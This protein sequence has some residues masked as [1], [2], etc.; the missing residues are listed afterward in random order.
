MK[1][2]RYAFFPGCVSKGACRELYDS[3]RIITSILGIDLVELEKASCCG[4]GVI[5]EIKP[6][7]ADALNTRTLGMASKLGLPIMT[8]C[9][10]C[11][12]VLSQV[13]HR[14]KNDKTLLEEMNQVIEHQGYAYD[15]TTEVKHLLWILIQDY[16]LENVAKH[17]AYKLHGIK[18]ASFYGCYLLRPSTVMQFEKDPQNPESLENVF[19]ML[20]AE[21]VIYDGRTKC[22][23]FPISMMDL[24]SSF[25]MAGKNLIEAKP[26]GADAIVTPCSLCHLNLDSRHPDVEKVM[27]Q[28]IDLPILHLSQLVGLALGVD[29]KKLKLDKHIVSTKLFLEKFEEAKGRNV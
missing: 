3:T 24:K 29:A 17:V 2:L 11:Q 26:K 23:G 14:L 6:R 20:G 21:P 13:N 5:E 9:S 16:G 7:T 28:K 27:G 1:Q 8:Q 4:A 10:T 12:G 15:G 18:L 25:T 19:T 22:C